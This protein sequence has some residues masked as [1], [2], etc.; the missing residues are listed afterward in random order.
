MRPLVAMII[1][2]AMVSPQATAISHHKQRQHP[3][4]ATTL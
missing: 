2:L 3:L 1:A 4:K